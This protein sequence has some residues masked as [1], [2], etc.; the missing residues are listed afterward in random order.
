M[1]QSVECSNEKQSMLSELPSVRS[2]LSF[3]NRWYVRRKAGLTRECFPLIIP[4]LIHDIG[5][6]PEIFTTLQRESDSNNPY[7]PRWGTI[8]LD[9][10]CASL[11]SSSPWNSHSAGLPCTRVARS[12]DCE[13]Y[14]FR[15][16]ML[17][18]FLKLVPWSAGYICSITAA[19]SKTR[20]ESYKDYWLLYPLK[21][22]CGYIV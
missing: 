4:V 1:G 6:K 21:P 14:F 13:L 18:S 2:L 12:I 17:F 7:G 5:P 11:K 3:A 16:Q 9:L 15:I 10:V 20:K 22:S 19:N 8:L